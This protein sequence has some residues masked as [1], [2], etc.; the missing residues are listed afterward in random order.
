[1]RPA[2]LTRSV[3]S[4]AETELKVVARPVRVKV[5][6]IFILFLLFSMKKFLCL[7]ILF[8]S[9]GKSRLLN[10]HQITAIAITK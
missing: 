9:L 1:M 4:M 5:W 6:I 8:L 10:D 3:F 2:W 7:N